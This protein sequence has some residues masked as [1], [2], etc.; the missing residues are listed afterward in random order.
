MIKN[1]KILVVGAGGFIGGHLIN[2]LLQ[3]LTILIFLLFLIFELKC[4]HTFSATF[5]VYPSTEI[6]LAALSV[7]IKIISQKFC[8]ANLQILYVAKILFFTAINI[9]FSRMFTCLYAAA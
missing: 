5:F 7:D 6:G 4:S 9:L 1:K 8:L 2:R 3:N